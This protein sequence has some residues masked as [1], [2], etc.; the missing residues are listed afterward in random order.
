MPHPLGQDM[1]KAKDYLNSFR[2]K[3]R[4]NERVLRYRKKAWLDVLRECVHGW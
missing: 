1:S 2:A 4:E 3:V